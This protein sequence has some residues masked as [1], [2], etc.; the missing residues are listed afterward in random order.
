MTVWGTGSLVV[1]TMTA[2]PSSSGGL[3]QSEEEGDSEAGGHGSRAD[4]HEAVGAAE[5]QDDQPHSV[6]EPAIAAAAGIDF[7]HNNG[8]YGDKLLPETMGSGCAKV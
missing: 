1:T 3:F 5:Q 7:V 8:A 6:P 4:G 2:W